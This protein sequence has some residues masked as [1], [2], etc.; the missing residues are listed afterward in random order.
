M[1]LTK[2]PAVGLLNWL[3]HLKVRLLQV[4]L[5]FLFIHV[6]C[7]PVF[8]CVLVCMDDLL[9]IGNNLDVLKSLRL[10]WILVFIGSIWANKNI[11]WDLKLLRIIKANTLFTV[12]Y[13]L[14]ILTHAGMLVSKPSSL[15]MQH[16]HKLGKA[17]GSLL[18]HPKSY[19]RLVGRLIYLTITR[20]NLAYCV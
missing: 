20:S 5:R 15:H 10:I 16:N 13:A 17:A 8:I 19:H 3:E 18:T 6:F 9:I 12:K 1:V 2:L 11:F 14:D 4:L 7:R